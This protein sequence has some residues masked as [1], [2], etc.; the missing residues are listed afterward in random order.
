M[1][2][3]VSIRNW[4]SLRAVDLDLGQFT[5][6][7]GDS[8]QGK[9]AFMRALAAVASNVTGV[10][11]I[12][13]GA[14]SAAISVR[15]GDA[16]V[17]LEYGKFS[18][19]TAPGWFYR[20]LVGGKE[21]KYTKLN[22]SVPKAITDA[23][24]INPV[25][26]GEVSVNYAGQHDG[27]FLL[28]SKPA[29]VARVL[30]ELTQVDRIFAAV[31]E[32]NRRRNSRA[33]VLRTREG[34]LAEV[35]AK[36]QQYVDLPGRLATCKQAEDAVEQANRLDGQVGALGD[37]LAS[38][39][40]AQAVLARTPAAAPPDGSVVDEAQRRLDEFRSAVRDWATANNS[41]AAA[42]EEVTR[43]EQVQV[44]LHAE[45]HAALVAAGQCPTCGQ[46]VT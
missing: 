24:G 40:A 16:L 38:L 6:I 27:P 8:R 13:K 35:T 7:L 31:A 10:D 2:E 36:A 5:A 39:E 30:G 25:R 18:N 26:P 3:T 45:L 32:A 19:D 17:T 33:G 34:D 12:T 14:K 43:Q 41:I 1:I 29:E 15:T 20:L 23:L 22:R 11:K 9:S 42:A 46:S 21:H 4:Q 44:D 37:A 28:T